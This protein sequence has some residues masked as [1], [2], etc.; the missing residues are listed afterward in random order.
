MKW[1]VHDYREREIQNLATMI[2][3]VWFVR[4]KPLSCE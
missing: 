4:E 1:T 3:I 2:H